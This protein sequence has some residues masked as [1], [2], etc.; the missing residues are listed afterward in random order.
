[1]TKLD[2]TKQDKQY[3]TATVKPHL[4]EIG[5]VHYLSITGKGDPSGRE[6]AEK[7][8]ALYPVAYAIKFD[9]KSRGRDFVVPKL[10]GLWWF[11]EKKFSG[12]SMTQSPV[13]VPR[14]EWEYRLMIRLPDF[15]S[16]IDFERA[17]ESTLQKKDNR[18][19]HTL[20]YFTLHE[21]R[22]IQILHV[23]P[24]STEPK[25]LETIRK[26]SEENDLSRNGL[27]HEIYLSDFRKTAGEKLKTI[28]RE[29][30]KESGR[31]S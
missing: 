25:T 22:C 11:D 23:G 31:D 21:G 14:S 8:E 2:L 4:V 9:F 15:V 5:E 6:F 30:V 1:M 3:Y 12:L 27:H 29:P 24:F 7:I 17:V 16:R 26:F 10:E 28:L 13:E 18:L 20:E 19:F